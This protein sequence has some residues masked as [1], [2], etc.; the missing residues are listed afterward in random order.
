MQPGVNRGDIDWASLKGSVLCPEQLFEIV[1]GEAVVG[2][3]ERGAHG[4]TGAV[5][6]VS[7]IS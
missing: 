1:T 6:G 2:Y 4:Q 5:L 7:G 3:F